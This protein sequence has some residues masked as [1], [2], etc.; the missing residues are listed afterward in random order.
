[1]LYTNNNKSQT[2]WSGKLYGY[3]LRNENYCSYNM[4]TLPNVPKIHIVLCGGGGG[5][6]MYEDQPGFENSGGGAGGMCYITN[7][8]NLSNTNF[9]FIVGNRG[10]RCMVYNEDDNPTSGGDTSLSWTINKINYNIIAYGGHDAYDGGNGSYDI[11]NGN[12][13]NYNIGGNNGRNRIEYNHVSIGCFNNNCTESLICRGGSIYQPTNVLLKYNN[14]STN[15]W[16]LLQKFEI[17]INIDANLKL[18]GDI[19][20]G[21]GGNCTGPFNG[22]DSMEGSDGGYGWILFVYDYNN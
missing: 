9:N 19:I 18:I 20:S 5:G 7:A 2:F 14:K 3:A 1:M 11:S 21:N 22:T 15:L 16:N 4:T 6:G 8:T 10:K 12:N 13:N 17:S